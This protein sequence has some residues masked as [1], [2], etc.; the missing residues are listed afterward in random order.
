MC[1]GAEGPICTVGDRLRIVGRA[2][3]H[4]SQKTLL[5]RIGQRPRDGCTAVNAVRIHALRIALRR[6]VAERVVGV[7][8]LEL[9]AGA[10]GSD[11]LREKSVRTSVLI[12]SRY[13][14]VNGTAGIGVGDPVV[15]YRL[16]QLAEV[17][18]V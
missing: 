7:V 11:A 9:C 12:R 5:V 1:Y 17:I 10:G 8:L 4:L 13:T 3:H 16:L 14:Y 15:P 18:N 2:I 6:N